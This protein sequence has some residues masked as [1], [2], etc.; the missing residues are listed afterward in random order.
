MALLKCIKI[1]IWLY[2][3]SK[4]ILTDYNTS[5]N[6]SDVDNNFLKPY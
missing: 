5:D 3:F 4:Y 1:T 6:A 2:I